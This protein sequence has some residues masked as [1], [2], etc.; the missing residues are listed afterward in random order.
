MLQKTADSLYANCLLPKDDRVLGSSSRPLKDCLS[1]LA[2]YL[3]DA[4]KA[5]EWSGRARA[6]ASPSVAPEHIGVPGAIFDTLQLSPVQPLLVTSGEE[7]DGAF[8]ALLPQAHDDAVLRLPLDAFE[9]LGLRHQP[10]ATCVVH[11]PLSRQ[12][13]VEA[14]QLLRGD[15]GPVC[16]VVEDAGWVDAGDEATMV[17]GL[18]HA[19]LHGRAVSLVS[20]R[21]L[22]IAGTGAVAFVDDGDMPARLHLETVREIPEPPA[23]CQAQART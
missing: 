20:P 15:P 17:D 12:A 9:R 16:P 21:S 3:I 22:L 13:C 8:V 10:I 7:R 5:A 4:R 6:V 14:E 19:A 23:V 1:M 2:G 11:R 18:I